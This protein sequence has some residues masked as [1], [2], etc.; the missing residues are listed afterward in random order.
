MSAETDLEHSLDRAGTLLLDACL[1]CRTAREGP[2]GAHQR[3]LLCAAIRKLQWAQ[4][5]LWKAGQS[6]QQTSPTHL[7]L[8]LV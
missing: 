6:W 8:S 3:E 5:D 2:I 4:D 1:A 7:Q